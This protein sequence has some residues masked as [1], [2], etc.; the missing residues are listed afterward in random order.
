MPNDYFHITIAWYEAKNPLAPEIIA[1]VERALANASQIL[2]IVFPNG[3]RG[4]ALRDSAVL[5]GNKSATVAFRVAESADLKK[6]QDI[7]LKFLSFENLADFK[8]NTFEKDTPIHVTLGKIRSKSGR[9]YQNAAA[10]LHAPE[11][12]RA[13]QGQSFTINTFRL[14]YSLAGQAW[15]EKM[16]YKF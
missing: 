13:S 6:L 10:N 16:S 14:T 1:R 5:L 9:Q 12:A 11:G 3:V 7:L 4:V 8:Y 15:Q 2:K